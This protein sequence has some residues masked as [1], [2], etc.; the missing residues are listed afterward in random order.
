[1]RRRIDEVPWWSAPVARLLFARE[2][3]A[4]ARAGELGIAPR[5]LL[6]GRNMLVRSWIDGVALHIAKPSEDDGFLPLRQDGAAAAASRRRL[7]QRSG[8]GA[9]LAARRRRPRLSHRLSACRPVSPARQC[10]SASPPT[11]ICATCS[12]I[13]GAM[14]RM[15]SPP[16]SAGCLR[17][18][19]GSRAFGW[20]PARRSTNGSPAA[21]FASPTGKAAARGWFTTRPKSRRGSKPIRACAR[22]PSW[23]SPTAAAGP[24]F[25]LLSR[26]T[27]IW[28]RNPCAP[29]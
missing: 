24:V 18:S 10:C 2:R 28:P 20:R 23:L 13:S 19:P 11:R 7:P 25:T 12:S 3:R 8:Q 5:L 4:L 22:S 29:C 9:E 17:A 14:R 15:P 27:R 6:A 26:P 16:P 1:M 21:S